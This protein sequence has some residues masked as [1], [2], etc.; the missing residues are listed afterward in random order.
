MLYGGSYTVGRG[1]NGGER[2]ERTYLVGIFIGVFV[3]AAEVAATHFQ[4]GK[5]G[6]VDKLD[7]VDIDYI[8]CCALACIF[9]GGEGNKN[10]GRCNAAVDDI[11]GYVQLLPA[12]T[13]GGLIVE[14][15]LGIFY[16]GVIFVFGVLVVGVPVNH[17]IYAGVVA[18]VS[19][20]IF[21]PYR[22]GVRFP[23][24]G[25]VITCVGRIGSIVIIRT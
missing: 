17:R 14:G 10:I 3:E 11:E 13:C 19:G 5:A 16:A 7:V 20:Y 23:G 15:G 22:H 9:I 8:V 1:R 12:V 18:G 2:A 21:Y 25:L 4:R 24:K 6:V